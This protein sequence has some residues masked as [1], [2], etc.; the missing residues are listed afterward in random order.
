[1]QKLSIAM[2]IVLLLSAVF[3]S[4]SDISFSNGATVRVTHDQVNVRSGAGTNYAVIGSADSQQV[5][6]YLGSANDSSG[7][8][9]YKIQYTPSSVGY[10]SSAFATVSTPSAPAI[11][12]QLVITAQPSLNVRA[13]AGTQYDVI[14][15]LDYGQTVDYYSLANGWYKIKLNQTIGYIS[16]DFAREATSAPIAGR[17]ITTA[18]NLIVR[19]KPNTSAAI[20]TRLPIGTELEYYRQ[21]DGWFEVKYNNQVAYISSLYSRIVG[22]QVVQ[23]RL[24]TTAGNLNVRSQ[25]NTS[26][27]ILS[28]L[29][30]GTQLE[31]Y[32]Q[33]DDWFEV[34]YNNQTAY[35]SSR[36]ARIVTDQ[37]VQGKVITTA[38]NLNVRSQPNTSAA[39]LGQLAI[40]TQL[41]YYRRL[42][43]WFE[44]KY[45]NQTAY[46]SS[47]YARVMEEAAPA[48]GP[49]IGQVVTTAAGL[50]VRTEPTTSAQ[51]LG[52]LPV[53]AVLDYSR[54][55]D[56]WF[57]V[58]YQSRR[59]YISSLYANIISDQP[60][61]PSR[62][63]VVASHGLNVRAQP[64]QEAAIV[65]SL[66]NHT[67]VDVYA[68]T[69]EW[70]EIRYND[71]PAYIYA[72]HT[73]AVSQ[74]PIDTTPVTSV[75]LDIFPVATRYQ[76]S[77]PIII[78]A[79]AIGPD[80]ASADYRFTLQA[81]ASNQTIITQEFSGNDA[82]V[83]TPQTA[84]RYRVIIEAK[85]KTATATQARASLEFDV[86]N[87][88]GNRYSYTIDYYGQTIDQAV[89]DQLSVSGR[90]MTD[91]SGRWVQA[92][93]DQIKA[94]MDPTNQIDWLYQQSRPDLGVITVT[95]NNLNV[96]PDASTSRP[97]HG[98]VQAGQQY[99]VLD[100]YQ[101]WYQIPFGDK[102]G[103]V[104]ADYVTYHGP[105]QM[106]AVFYTIPNLD[107]SR[108][109]Y[110]FL[111]LRHYTGVTSRALNV[112][113]QGM[114]ILHDQGA[115]FVQ[116][117]KSAGINEVYLVSHALLETGNGTSQLANGF[118]YNPTTDDIL[119]YGSPAKTGYVKVYNMFGIGA[120]DSAP[121]GGG[122]RFAY[123]EGWTT[124]AEAIIGGARWIG[125]AYIN[126]P[127]RQ[128]HTL[129]SMKWN[130]YQ[131]SHQ[132][133]TDI[134][135]AIKQTAQMHRIYS[136]SD[137]H[138][139]RFI[140]PQF[141]A[142]DQ[143]Y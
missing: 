23:G 121:V 38:G 59:A 143:P 36:Y 4:Y 44:V 111:D 25:P 52:Y 31:Y 14:G 9:W 43:G 57:E 53:G 51:I 102:A 90:A 34:K 10:I 104:M 126:S 84:G 60:S 80:P 3:A 78:T 50:R 89:L 15:S 122:V 91:A 67:I 13:A 115:A 85:N 54:Q 119:P 47:R 142:S 11:A 101:N 131:N 88:Q 42:D 39:I 124:P 130:I 116:A 29:P 113:L 127:H 24:I 64:S 100:I 8:A 86:E 5:Y 103:W 129:Y 26:A 40:N 140:L 56:G 97:P 21:L 135:W 17:V 99:Q 33:L 82:L 95:H 94:A 37:P 96:R 110:Q 123:Q 83:W 70:Y 108:A 77:V 138:S 92:N 66:A 49:A 74:G 117:S 112:F 69:G 20:L 132:Y 58:N 141:R 125:Q 55:L 32:R 120:V 1:M 45:N 73:E 139:F 22:N 105:G 62:V 136:Q 68:Q 109:M 6:P 2:V 76:L 41:D 30:L 46:I 19:A 114:G 98:Q 12:G 72:A 65:G 18:G 93:K 133:A 28:R 75:G 134:G 79:R 118:Y 16:A 128:Q 63:R 107:F 106:E 27:A 71:A 7:S 61:H 35:I 137:S 48:P 87:V 81:T